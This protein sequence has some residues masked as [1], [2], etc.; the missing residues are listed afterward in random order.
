MGASAAVLAVFVVPGM[1]MSAAGGAGPGPGYDPPVITPDPDIPHRHPNDV[2]GRR[3]DVR[4]VEVVGYQTRGRTLRLYYTVDQSSD[5]SS[6]IEP[7]RLE[8]RADS[9][10]V[11][12][13]R[14][15]SR[16]PDQV[17]SHLLLTSSIDVPL[18]EPLG[19]RVLQDAGRDG[20]LVPIEQRYVGGSDLA[21][22]PLS[23]AGR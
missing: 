10:V 16:A 3:P 12:L 20:A 1:V 5:C 7:P 19:R 2:D 8:E 9:V 15:P 17:C 18:A 22:P 13:E 11:R 6:R 14:V 23:R 21:T 4:E